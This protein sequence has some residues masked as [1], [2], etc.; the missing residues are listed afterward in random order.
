MQPDRT[1]TLLV[2]GTGLALVGL[3]GARTLFPPEP[4]LPRIAA[5]PAFALTDQHGAKLAVGDLKGKVWA[6]NFIF[7]SCPDVCPLLTRQ[8][9][10]LRKRTLSEGLALRYVS[11]SVDPETDTPEALTRFAKLHGAVFDDWSFL[12]GPIEDVKA[13]VV[14]G[15]RQAMEHKLEAGKANVLHGT[16]FVLVD[17]QGNIRGFYE[18]T[19]QG[20]VQLADDAERLEAEKG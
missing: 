15:F 2:A 18:S 4:E 1:R 14:Q 19:E 20:L 17:K 9:G 5:L 8:M 3:I 10:L 6:A 13:V 12:T 11:F 7:T 16:H